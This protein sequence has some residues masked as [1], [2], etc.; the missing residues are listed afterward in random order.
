MKEWRTL[1]LENLAITLWLSSVVC[2]FLMTAGNRKKNRE[3]AGWVY[4][5]CFA[6]VRY[7]S[8]ASIVR[9]VTNVLLVSI[10][11]ASGLTI[12]SAAKTT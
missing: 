2:L 5:A 12:V 6:I 1:L 3:I 7:I 11:I 10:T 4:I 8:L 9:A